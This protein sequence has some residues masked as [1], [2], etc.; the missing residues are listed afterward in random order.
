MKKMTNEII[1][2]DEGFAATVDDKE[3]FFPTAELH[4]VGC[5]NCIWKIHDQCPHGLKENEVYSVK[6]LQ[7]STELISSGAGI[8]QDM[9][10]FLVGL[11]GKGDG[12]T[13]IW[14]KFHIYK[15]R[16]EETSDYKDYHDL[17]KKIQ[18]QEKHAFAQGGK[19]SEEDQDKLDRLK[20][21]RN[22]AKLWWV[23]IN[24]HIIQ[25][26]QK[27]AD[28]SVKKSEGGKRSGMPAGNI[29]FFVNQ[30]SKK[31]EEKEK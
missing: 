1:P 3:I 15:V 22:A 11:A 24:S 27:V 20:M 6:G 23:K 25:S 28:R 21:D 7:S 5:K 2:K 14:E 19:L 13:E 30:E 29:N 10:Q 12:L 17:K 16:I 31:L 8:C 4:N 18:E 9:M 26:L